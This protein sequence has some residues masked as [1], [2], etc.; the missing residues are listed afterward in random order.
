VL[1]FFRRVLARPSPVARKLADSSYTIYLF[2]HATVVVLTIWMMRWSIGDFLKYAIVVCVT[3][4]FT[5]AL[6]RLVIARVPLLTLLF[7]GHRRRVR[8]EPR[9]DVPMAHA[10]RRAPADSSS[11]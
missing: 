3:F 2:H 1:V 7:N 6:H 9:D 4:T 5:F 11:A 10:L 8:H